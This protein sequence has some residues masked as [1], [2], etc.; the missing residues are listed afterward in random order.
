MICQARLLAVAS[1]PAFGQARL[2]WR[3]RRAFT[4]VELLLV[5]AII[6]VLMA[7]L[8]PAVQ[9]ARESARTAQCK[10]NLKQLALA[11]LNHHD[12]Q[13]HFPTGGWGWFW[14][15]DPDRGFGK[16]QPGG[17]MY[18]LLPYCEQGALYE[19][20]ADGDPQT[21]TRDQ[22]VG[23]ARVVEA[24]LVILNCPS[25]RENKPYPLTN[26]EGGALGF[27]NSLTP[28]MA[29]RSDYAINSG[30]VYNEWHNATLGQGPAS[31]ADAAAWTANRSWGSDQP[32]F[33]MTPD[34][35]ESMSGV[36]FE[37]SMV[38]I[39][40]VTDGLANT[41]LVAE[42]YIPLAHYETGLNRGDNE[43]WCTGFNNDNYRRTGRLA[44]AQVLGLTPIPDS[45]PE[46][47]VPD[48][49]GR[50]GSAHANLWSASFCDGS[51]RSVSYD[52]DWRIHRDLGNRGDGNCS[53]KADF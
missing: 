51:V 35:D 25:R 40:H 32:K 26:H 23:A 33:L 27:F 48:A 20:A 7:L 10:N 15:G 22:R 44:A 50:F 14:L 41:Y 5:F 30:H 12:G 52:V 29:G 34:G 1:T 31:Y 46:D 4:L 45:A 47:G 18:N 38:S 53:A 49:L 42:R 13:G 37:R 8:F 24:P 3:A 9:A 6:S 43:T 19:R 11:A 39:Q 36:S 28:A 21:L 2:P 16:N 17:W